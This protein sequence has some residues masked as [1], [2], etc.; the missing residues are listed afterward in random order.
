MTYRKTLLRWTSKTGPVRLG[1]ELPPSAIVGRS[2]GKALTEAAGQVTSA[3]FLVVDVA[4]VELSLVR[5]AVQAYQEAGGTARLCLSGGRRLLSEVDALGLDND[6]VGLMLD[7]VDADT[8]WADLAWD[9]IEAIRFS[10]EFLD[11]A[12]RD[13]RT[14]CI[15]ESMLAL[16]REVGVRTLGW[17]QAPDDVSVLGRYDFDYF[18][19]AND[20][21]PSSGASDS[22][23]KRSR[24]GDAM[25]AGR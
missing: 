3:R 8:S 1:A 2:F 12:R 24:S 7:R 4:S 22:V 17:S 5:R 13:M 20:A 14:S 15:L 11:H 6:R 25:A 16:S 18:R 19:M 21:E 9:R 10:P 23:S